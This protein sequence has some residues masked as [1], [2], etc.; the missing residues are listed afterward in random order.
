MNR[1]TFLELLS[2]VEDVNKFIDK[3]EELGIDICEN[4]LVS[5]VYKLFDTIISDSYGQ[6]GLEWVQW[7][8]YEKSNNP[9]L[10]AYETDEQG[11]EVEIIRNVDELYNYLEKY[12]TKI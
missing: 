5:S 9:E 4:P 12:H 11:N 6:E 7:W 1:T 3:L 8:V 2:L 10:K